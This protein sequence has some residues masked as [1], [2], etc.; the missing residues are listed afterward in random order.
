MGRKEGRELI[1]EGRRALTWDR[2]GPAGG[3]SSPAGS[4][5]VA[6]PKGGFC[7]KLSEGPLPIR[8]QPSG[9]TGTEKRG[10]V[11]PAGAWRDG[12]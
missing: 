12:D 9:R 7:W 3:A 11:D 2:R 5:K 10:A 6:G 4:H 8:V 1:G